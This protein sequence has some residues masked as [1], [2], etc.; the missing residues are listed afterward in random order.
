MGYWFRSSQGID[1]GGQREDKRIKVKQ[2]YVEIAA[3][4]AVARNDNSFY[5]H[6]LFGLWYSYEVLRS[7]TS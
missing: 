1:K 7:S 4:P 6:S 5:L 2:S 3:L